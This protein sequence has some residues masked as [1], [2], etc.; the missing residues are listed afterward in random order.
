[1]F[2]PIFF[3]PLAGGPPFC[4]PFLHLTTLWVPYPLPEK[5]R[6]FCGWE[7]K[8][9]IKIAVH[10]GCPTSPCS[11]FFLTT[12]RVPHPL[13]LLQRV[14]FHTVRRTTIH[15]QLTVTCPLETRNSSSANR[16][17]RPRQ[18]RSI[19][20]SVVARTEMTVQTM[21]NLAPRKKALVLSDP[22]IKI[23]RL[24]N[25]SNKMKATNDNPTEDS[26]RF[27]RPTSGGR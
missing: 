4:L 21:Q 2:R 22:P 26:G 20:I 24:L 27:P 3:E 19:C 1:M 10:A 7:G 13:P 6:S 25:A 15:F 23:W 12:P 11:F 14:E 9:G 5:A 18:S 17:S 8:G 16:F